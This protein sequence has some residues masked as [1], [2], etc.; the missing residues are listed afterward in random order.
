MKYDS[1]TWRL[2]VRFLP[3][4]FRSSPSQLIFL[5]RLISHVWCLVCKILHN[6]RF[7]KC[8]FLS[9][10]KRILNKSSTV[11]YIYIYIIFYTFAVHAC[12]LPLFSYLR[13]RWKRKWTLSISDKRLEKRF[14]LIFYP[15][16]V[17]NGKEENE[18]AMHQHFN[19][20]HILAFNYNIN[21]I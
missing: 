15:F 10:P 11:I 1:R 20:F 3:I 12:I 17:Y 21:I 4:T 2:R 19:T 16:L 7:C 14:N 9:S 5:I 13:I 8:R 18:N 6:I